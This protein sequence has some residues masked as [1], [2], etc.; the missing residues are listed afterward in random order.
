MT[1]RF[2]GKSVLVIG[3][4][5]GIGL[6]A[7][8]AFCSEGADVALTGRN[9]QTLK[10]VDDELRVLTV[11]SDLTDLDQSRRAVEQAASALG[12][13]DVL[14]VNAGISSFA[15][16]AAITP[17]EWD[18]CFAVNLRGAVFSIQYALPYIEDGGSIVTS[19]SIGSSMGVPGTLAY[20]AAKAGLHSATRVLAAE[21]MPRRIRVNMVGI[22]PTKTR[23]YKRDASEEQI[24][25]VERR[26]SSANPMGRMGTPEE[27]AQAVLFL[28]S[29]DASYI[30]GVNLYVDGG[31]V[32]L[33][34]GGGSDAKVPRTD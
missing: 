27:I 14:F 4:N 32:E 17:E 28:A 2:K 7:V 6:A 34:T 33:R 1:N 30:T 10:A 9:P 29:D 24:D 22:G 20:S 16:V 13:L 12:K 8:R 21:L 15:S 25:I 26:L 11:A 3:G 19:G 23:L 18:K 5:S 31:Q